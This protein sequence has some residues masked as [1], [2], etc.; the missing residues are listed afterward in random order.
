[1]WHKQWSRADHQFSYGTFGGTD[2]VVSGNL[3]APTENYASYNSTVTGGMNLHDVNRR[4][5]AVSWQDFTVGVSNP[6]LYRTDLLVQ[7]NSFARFELANSDDPAT[8]TEAYIL[9]PVVADWSAGS[10]KVL[11]WK[12]LF[13]GYAGK[14]IHF[15]D[16]EGVFRKAVAL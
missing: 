1:M 15:F 5:G 6:N 13:A 16:A 14:Y 4:V 11:L 10:A 2:G 3:I 8:T 9:P 12:S 7:T